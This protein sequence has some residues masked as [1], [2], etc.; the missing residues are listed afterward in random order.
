MPSRT[1]SAVDV[2]EG[3][4]RKR[5]RWQPLEDHEAEEDGNEDLADTEE[6]GEEESSGSEQV[7]PSSFSATRFILTDS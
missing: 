2:E 7:L 5:V 1:S 3:P 4:P 6:T